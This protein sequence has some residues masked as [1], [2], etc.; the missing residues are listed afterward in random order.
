LEAV[1]PGFFSS[2]M[3]V[4]FSFIATNLAFLFRAFIPTSPLF[5]SKWI[6]HPY[7]R[8]LSRAMCLFN[9][10]AVTSVPAPDS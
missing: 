4:A 1:A 3:P 8:G 7:S 9:G 2:S 6:P 5:L 10:M